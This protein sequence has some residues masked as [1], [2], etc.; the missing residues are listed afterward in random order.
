[1][2]NLKT[3][4]IPVAILVLGVGSAFATNKAKT[5]KKASIIAYHFDPAAPVEK[6]ILVGEVDCNT[7]SGA[8]CTELVN[9]SPK[10]MQTRIS[11]TECGQALFRN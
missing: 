11:D 2:K 4:M 3:F 10:T 1:M 6:C 5:D 8:V 7:T 9:G